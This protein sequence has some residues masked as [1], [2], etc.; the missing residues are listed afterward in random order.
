MRSDHAAF[1]P[2]SVSGSAPSITREEAMRLV[3]T[4]PRDVTGSAAGL[5]SIFV[6]NDSERDEPSRESGQQTKLFA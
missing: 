5:S 2:E 6:P 1:A 3:Q 4:Q